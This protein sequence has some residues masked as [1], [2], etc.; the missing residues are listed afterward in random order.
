[1]IIA[2]ITDMH[3]TADGELYNGRIAVND[4]L[5][6]VIERLNAIAPDVIL[7]TGDLTGTGAA[8]E[9]VEL[10]E[11]LAAAKAPLYMVPGNHD[12]R[13]RLRAFF[14]D[15]T[16]LPAEGFAHYV[17]DDY[18]RALIGVD[19]TLPNTPRGEICEDRLVGLEEPDGP[20]A[21]DDLF[22]LHVSLLTRARAERP[23]TLDTSR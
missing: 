6:A 10:R 20:P 13:A 21:T 1:M 16:Y 9:Y 3:L 18:P 23:P 19:T 15:H 4:K 17:I 5:R 11:I 14:P 7:A 22:E 2:Q 8:E 12:D